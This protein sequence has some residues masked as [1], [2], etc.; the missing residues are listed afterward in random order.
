VGQF[1]FHV[2]VCA[3]NKDWPK[4]LM[5]LLVWH[6]LHSRTVVMGTMDAIDVTRCNATNVRFEAAVQ[7]T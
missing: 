6:V 4:L 3:H 7:K 2:H 1:S 5:K